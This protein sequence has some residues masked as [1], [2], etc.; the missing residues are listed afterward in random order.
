MRYMPL[1]GRWQ[2]VVFRRHVRNILLKLSKSTAH[3]EEAFWDVIGYSV[4]I[5]GEGVGMIPFPLKRAH[6]KEAVLRR[7][8]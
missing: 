3:G 8:S 5:R 1:E 6:V 2:D 7:T 4:V